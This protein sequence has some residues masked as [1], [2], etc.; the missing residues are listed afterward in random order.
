M[1]QEQS[2]V[3]LGESNVRVSCILSRTTCEA[4]FGTLCERSWLCMTASNGVRLVL[5]GGYLF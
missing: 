4:D 3:V 1:H 5:D 2:A